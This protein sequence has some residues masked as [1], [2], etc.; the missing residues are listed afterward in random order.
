MSK[1]NTKSYHIHLRFQV[2]GLLSRKEVISAILRYIDNQGFNRTRTSKSENILTINSI[3]S[4]ESDALKGTITISTNSDLQTASRIAITIET[5]K[6]IGSLRADFIIVS[7]HEELDKDTSGN[8]TGV[9]EIP[10]NKQNHHVCGKDSMQNQFSKD[11]YPSK[12]EQLERRSTID[13]LIRKVTRVDG[14]DV[15]IFVALVLMVIVP[16]TV[17]TSKIPANNIMSYIYQ[18]L[19]IGTTWSFIR[20]FIRK[21]PGEVS[22][23]LSNTLEDINYATPSNK[24][25]LPSDQQ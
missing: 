25:Q 7:I 23:I 15:I 3:E 24:E 4:D 20:Y 6:Q 12:L 2:N 10:K 17:T 5:L 19:I 22:N 14:A 21:K 8:M 1:A 16:F 18:L 11:D 13:A 9:A